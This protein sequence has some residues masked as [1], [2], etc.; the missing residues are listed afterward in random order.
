[1]KKL[2]KNILDSVH[3]NLIVIIIFSIF[4]ALET[5]QLDYSV[6]SPGGLINVDNRI[7]NKEYY[8]KG[9]FNLTYVSYRKG[10]IMNL[11]IAKILPTHDIIKNKDIT[12]SN[13]DMIDSMK[14]DLIQIEQA[15]SNA[16]YISYKYAN[17]EYSI[18]D[19]YNYV[20]YIDPKAQTELKVGDRVIKCDNKE[21]A[22]FEEIQT[23]IKSHKVNDDVTLTVMRGNRKINTKSKVLDNNVVGIL[24]SKVFTYDLNPNMTYK[25]D[26]NESGSSGGLL[27][28]LSMYNALVEEDITKG[29]KIAGTGTIEYDGSVNEISGVRYKILGAA[30]KKIDLFIVPSGNYDEAKEVVEQ[31]NLNIKLL[32]ADSFEQVLNDLKNYN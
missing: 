22:S 20:Y 12:L 21:T 5:Y 24:I 29:M 27:L 8:S 2:I 6:Y 31:N 28:A 10:T 16:T 9:S 11:L 17:K 3:R 4:L 30:K 7:S 18:K 25:Y 13:E 32:R 26:H 19:E 14:R 1:M 15:V 23:C